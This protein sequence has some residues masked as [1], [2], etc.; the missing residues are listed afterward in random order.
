MR[1]GMWDELRDFDAHMG[2]DELRRRFC[3]RVT[4]TFERWIAPD[5]AHFREQL[6]FALGR[7]DEG[8]SLL[9]YF[10]RY[11]NPLPPR[12]REIR[13]MDIGSGNG[14][15]ALALANHRRYRVY[16]LDLVPNHDLL[17]LRRVLPVPVRSLVAN[18]EKA[19]VATETFDIVLLLDTIE[20]VARPRLLASEIMRILRPGGVCMITTPARLRHLF[21]RDPHYGVRGLVLLPNELQRLIVDRILRRR[22]RDAFG[23]DAKA[24]DV[25]HIYWHVSEIAGLFPGPKDVDVLFNQP[26]QPAARFTE[27]WFRHKFRRFLYDRILIYKKAGVPRNGSKG[28][29][30]FVWC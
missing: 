28:A 12:T 19:P 11:A 5:E 1:G 14:G 15:V 2:W 6:I 10:E 23:R 18:G 22:V 21:S 25:T 4:Q 30:P 24:Y 16:T 29:A 7:F 27:E 20:H 17:S 9:R 13:V 3:E 8:A 26:F